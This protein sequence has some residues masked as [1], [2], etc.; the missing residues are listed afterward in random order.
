VNSRGFFISF[1]VFLIATSIIAMH[2]ASKKVDFGQER[3]HIEGAAFNNVNNAFNN[4]YEEVVSL[5]K[6]GYA[7]IVQQ[8]A[9]PFSYDLNRNSIILGQRVPVRQGLLD[10]YIDALNIYRIFASSH[11]AT[12]LN[13]SANALKNAE[14]GGGEA[15]PDLNYAILPQCLLYDVNSGNY[16]VLRRLVSGQ[17][18]CTADFDYSSIETFDVNILLDSTQCASGSISGTLARTDDFD[19]AEEDPYFRIRINETGPDCPGAGCVATATGTA[20]YYGH[21]D[22]EDYGAA[23]SLDWLRISCNAGDWARVKLG[24]ESDEDVFPFVAQNFIPAQ[25]FDVD[26][27]ATFGGKVDLFYFTGFSVSV[28]KANF[29]VKRST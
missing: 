6:E 12:D 9:M 18:G 2:D 10:S 22:P 17:L 14:W 1:M 7:R 3:Q 15:N 16:M 23:E 28:E 8:R 20:D 21:F 29:P 4:I 19:Q 27:N 25:P 5:N 13:I 26:L 11:Q 24:M